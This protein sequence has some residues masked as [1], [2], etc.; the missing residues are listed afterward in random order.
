MKAGLRVCFLT[1]NFSVVNYL[2]LISFHSCLYLFLTS[3]ELFCY[4]LKIFSK[5]FSHRAGTVYVENK[6]RL[7]V[8]T[9]TIQ[10]RQR[11]T[12]WLFQ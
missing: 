4:L 10:V 2:F 3:I 8:L 5:G 7:T 9:G 12:S 1:F 11:A 6:L